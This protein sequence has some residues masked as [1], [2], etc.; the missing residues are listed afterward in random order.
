[1]SATTTAR[2][3]ESAE[4]I[5]RAQRAFAFWRNAIG[6]KALMAVTGAVLFVYVVGHLLGNLQVYAGPAQIDAYSRFLH[7]N[8]GLLWTAR[9]I[10]L[11][12]VIVHAGAGIQ[13]WFQKRRARPVPYRSRGNVQAS[14]GSRTMI[15]SG[16]V[17]LAFVVYHLLD[18]TV[19]TANPSFVD[20][21]PYRNMVA[22]FRRVPSAIAYL[23]AMAGLGFHLQHG[24]WSMFQSLGVTNP[25][26]MGGVKQVAALV[27]VLVF[28][29]FASI[30]VAILTGL[31]G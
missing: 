1:M 10:L 18:L 11:A 19:G 2:P 25:R 13:L 17:I 29:G 22:S 3:V 5:T 24:L 26:W 21:D 12:A 15:W 31:V 20:L 8:P 28:L 4:R 23:V 30:P 7:S 27:A 14:I 16:L 6:K 9:V